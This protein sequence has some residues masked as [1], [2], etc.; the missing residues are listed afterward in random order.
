MSVIVLPNG[1]RI[2]TE[3]LDANQVTS[4]LTEL[5]KQQ[6]TL[7]T[8]IGGEIDLSTASAEEI[9]E[10]RRRKEELGGTVTGTKA[11]TADSLKDPDVDYTSGLQDFRIRAGFSNIVTTLNL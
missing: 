7:F 2:N 1:Q 9:N 10:F 8:D 4:A 5:Q 6:P 11:D 3:G